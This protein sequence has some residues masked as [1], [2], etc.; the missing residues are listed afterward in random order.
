MT[1]NGLAIPAYEDAIQIAKQLHSK[2]PYV[3][4]I[5]WDFAIDI[6]SKAI[7]LEWEGTY[8]DIKFIEATQGPVFNAYHWERFA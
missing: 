1:F 8:N 7:L 4:C 5:G 3:G 6:N 2:V